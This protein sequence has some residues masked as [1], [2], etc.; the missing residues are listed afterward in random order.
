MIPL[1]LE[2][3]GLMLFVGISAFFAAAE[4]SFLSMSAVRVHHLLE[5]KVPGAE[6]LSRLRAKRRRVVVSLLIGGNVANVAASAIATSAS[7]AL[8]G[9]NGIGIAIGVMSFLLL[10]LGDIAPKSAATTYGESFALAFSPLIEAFYFASYP[11]VAVFEAINRLIPGVYSHA[12]GIE[13][14]TEAEVRSAVKLGA[15]HKSIS[16]RAREFIENA[17]EFDTKPVSKAMTAKGSVVSLPA[18]MPVSEAYKKAVGSEHSRFPVIDGQNKVV[19]TVS[20][21][22][23][24]RAILQHPGWTAEQAAWKPVV[25][26]ETDKI[27]HAFDTLQSLGRNIAVVVDA[28]GEFAG[29]VTIED[30]LEELVGELV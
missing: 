13:R 14:F 24:G 22:L 21:K 23:L 30:L 17:L 5:H 19:G 18:D 10:T 25:F 9:D 7:I 3:A 11:L 16:E 28:N 12:T 4:V 15:K 2:A 26:R 20:E 1:I 6:S 29:V 27:H 8:F